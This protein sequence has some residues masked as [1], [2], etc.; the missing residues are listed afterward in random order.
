MIAMARSGEQRV[1]VVE[2]FTQNGGSPIMTQR[3][4]RAVNKQNFQYWSHNN[5]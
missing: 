2:E 5:P 3:A 1:F 4:F